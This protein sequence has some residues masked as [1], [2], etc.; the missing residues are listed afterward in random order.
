[1]NLLTT[2]IQRITALFVILCIAF[3]VNA[4][5]RTFASLAEMN[6]DAT[7]ASG[8]KV[9]IEG[10][11]VVEYIMESFFVLRDKDGDATCVNYDYYFREFQQKRLEGL[12]EYPETPPVKPGDVFKKYVATVN[13]TNNRIELAPVLDMDWL[14]FKGFKV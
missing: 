2:L 13:Y 14:E 8:D 11:L 1:M 4:V 7:L 12:E 9:T 10:D 5:D 6:A 3:N